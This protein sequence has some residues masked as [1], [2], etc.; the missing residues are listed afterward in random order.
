MH[1]NQFSAREVLE[2]AVQQSG[3]SVASWQEQQEIVRYAKL[4]DLTRELKK[5]GAHNVNGGRPDGLTGR[6]R[7]Q[8]LTQA[9]ERFREA[10]GTL[11][12]S[13]QVW[14]LCLYKDII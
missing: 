6:R 1:V 8:A 3:L 12:A 14:Y 13:Y 7:I 5:L 4:S 10:E 9:Y 11:P 2:Q